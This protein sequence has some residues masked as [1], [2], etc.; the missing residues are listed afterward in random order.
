VTLPLP[1]RHHSEPG[2]PLS[3]AMEDYLK[4]IYRLQERNQRVTTQ[5]I[6]ERLSVAPPSVTHMVKRLAARGLIT[7]EPY[8]GVQLTEAGVHVGREMIRHH[9]LLELY[10]TQALGFEQDEVHAEAER[11]EHFISEEFEERIDQ[12]LGRPTRDPHGSPIPA[13]PPKV[14][15]GTVCTLAELELYSV[16][17][18]IGCCREA[19]LAIGERVTVLGRPPGGKLH[20]RVG[21]EEMLFDPALACE[22]SVERA[23]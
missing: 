22:V 21:R 18:V 8:R 1:G 9:R 12:I 4:E 15:A 3:A 13:R 6:A 2:P 11:L 10:L 23:R 19:G 16:A 7:H 14:T 20:L 5:V 17:A